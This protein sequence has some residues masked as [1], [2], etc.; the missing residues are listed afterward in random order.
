MA[1]PPLELTALPPT[2]VG[3]ITT[4]IIE[5]PDA[6]AVDSRQAR[7]LAMATYGGNGG[8]GM[9][10]RPYA[11]DPQGEQIVKSGQAPP[12]A[13]PADARFRQDYTFTER[14]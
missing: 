2:R 8:M 3:Q 6:G 1:R 14:I 11:V 7:Q 4:V 9:P 12:A 13:W 10:G 5:G